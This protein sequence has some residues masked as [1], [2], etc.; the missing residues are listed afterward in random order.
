MRWLATVVLTATLASAQR[1]ATP[2]IEGPA[3]TNLIVK[4]VPPV[5]PPIALQARVQGVV[6]VV[7]QLSTEG[8]VTNIA[9]TAGPALLRQ[10]G[11]DAVQTWTFRPYILNGVPTEV[12]ADFDIVFKLP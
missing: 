10:A 8:K 3:A 2:R 5:Y 9:V 1:A 6:H 7:L 11:M 12:A 4:Q